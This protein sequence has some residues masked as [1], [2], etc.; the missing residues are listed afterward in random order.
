MSIVP[1]AAQVGV[2]VGSGDY[3][4]S[5][6][7][8][9]VDLIAA[10]D[11][12]KTGF[13]LPTGQPLDN[14]WFPFSTQ[15][16]VQNG[17]TYAVMI[18]AQHHFYDDASASVDCGTGSGSTSGSPPIITPQDVTLFKSCLP[19][20]PHTN[21]GILGQRWECQVDVTAAVTPF[22]GDIILHDVFS[23][24]PLVNGQILLG[25]SVS[26][27]GSCFQGDCLISGANFD[28]SGS[29]SFTFDVFVEASG[30]ADVYP[31]ENCVTGEIDDGS[32]TLQPLT[33][34]CTTDQWVPRSQVVKTCDPMPENATAPYTMNCSIEVT[35]SG[36]VGGTYVSV[37]DAF[38]AQPPSVATVQ[39]TFM[40]VTSTENWDCID[41]QLN[42][43]GSIGICELPAE[44]LMA[45]GGTSTLDISFQF[46]VDQAPTQVAN[47]RFTDI[48]S[49]SYL[50][51][52][53]GQRSALRS[54]IQSGTNQNSGW[55]QMP[56]GCVYVDVP[57]PQ[58]ETKVETK[59]TK[60]C[61]QPTL[62]NHNGTWGYLWQCE[63]EVEVTPSPFAGTVSFTDDGSQ[64]SMVTSE[65]VSVSDPLC[66]GLGTDTLDCT[67]Q[68]ATFS[69]PHI[70]HY[71]LF[72]PY[73]QTDE[74]IEWKNCIRGA[75]ETAAGT[76]P[77]VP[78][79]TGRFIKPT[80][81]PV[82]D[83]PKDI[84]L[85]KVCE[86]DGRETEYDGQAG[87]AWDC[88][89]IVTAAP[90]PF[91]GTFTFTENASSITGSTGQI[92]AIDQPQPADWTCLPNVPTAATDCT[93]AGANF[94][95]SGT[96]TIGFTLF[97]PNSGETVE[98]KNCVSGFYTPDEKGDTG[99]EP[100]EVK[101]NCEGITWKPTVV[102]TPPSFDIKKSCRG[103]FDQRE[104][105]QSY[106]CTIFITQTGGDPITQPLTLNELFSSTTTGQSATQFMIGLQGTT[107]WDCDMS[108]ASCSILPADFNGN[109]GHQI[110]A[111]FL[112]PNGT[113]VEQDFQNCASLTMGDAE[114]AN[115]P[116]VDLDEPIVDPVGDPAF[117][118]EKQ[119]KPLGERQVMGPSAWFQ[120]WSCTITVT[121]NGVP[122]ADP[123][124]IDEDMLYGSNDGSQSVTSITS[125]DP[126]HC[127]PAP[128]GPNGN[129]PVCGIQGNQ[130]PHNTSTLDVTLN[131]FG[132][133][134]DQ[135]GA[136]NCVSV[137]MGEISNAAAGD[138]LA[139]DCFE[140]IA[141]PEPKEPQIDLVKTC[142][143][144]TQTGTGQWSV[145]C[146]LTITGQNLP[147]GEQFRVTDE[148]MSSNTQ[149]ATFGVMNAGTN[150]CGGGPIAGG[151]MAGCDLTT[152]MINANGGTLSI[153]YTGT[154]VGPAGR[155]LDGPRAQNCAFVDVPGLGLHGP[156]GGNGKSCVP[157]E[158]KETISS[159][160]SDIA[161]DPEVPGGGSPDVGGV[162]V[163]NPPLDATGVATPFVPAPAEPF[164]TKTCEPLVFA[165][166]AQTATANCEITVGFPANDP[167][168]IN[169]ITD[170]MARVGAFGDDIVVGN[171]PPLTGQQQMGCQS[172]PPA[173]T[174]C[175]G[176]SLSSM[177]AGGTFTLNWTAEI[178]R[179]QDEREVYRNCAALYFGLL[180][181]ASTFLSA[182]HVFDITVEG[183]KAQDADATPAPTPTP[184]PIIEH[185]LKTRKLQNTDCVA[186]RN[187]Q[188]YTCGFRITVTNEGTAPYNGPLVVTDTF[189]SPWA[190]AITQTSQGGWFCAQPVG[191]AVSC[192]H[193]GLN[194]PAG[195]FAYI[196]LDMEVQ[197][198]VNGGQW[199]NCAAVGIP[200]DRKQRVAAIQQVM[201]A[202]GLAAGPVDGLPGAKTYAALAELQKSLGLPIS[203]EF[204]DALFAALGLPLAKPGEKSC[205]VADLPNMPKPPLQCERATTV[206]KGESCQC[207]YDNM[208]RRNATACQCTGGYAFVAG[209]GCVK[210]IVTP[211]P[212]PT[213]PPLL[214]TRTC[215]KR[216]TRLRGDECVCLDQKNAVK[217]SDTTCGCRNGGPMIGGKCLPITITPK[218][219]NPDATD[220]PVGTSEPDKCK[221]RLN[222]ICIK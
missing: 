127:S 44:D 164:I 90:A 167:R 205:V 170:I 68:G 24:T 51:K 35:G 69:S 41:H 191:G 74:K 115:A 45:A 13:S 207:R 134:A 175:T 82:F 208:I 210:Q 92:I 149:T 197:G 88:K 60:D 86:E 97:A 192:E 65:F 48:H 146:T 50:D 181:T 8:N 54:P 168:Q 3:P 49:G 106:A 1:V 176:P 214:E 61:D 220:D 17:Q 221:I 182:C 150:A 19:P 107:G 110:G 70:V 162:D 39:P 52:L 81:V 18:E 62:T 94:D 173:A 174:S 91:A 189:G 15:S 63:A 124:W 119:C 156:A 23:N 132:G 130:F 98:W 72:T 202:R 118:V 141:P 194:L 163:T 193:S 171:M 122:F 139:E 140:I 121:S 133:A 100:R 101:G 83:P 78:M 190:Q 67:Y 7:Q 113:L 155:P 75:A 179:P 203:R 169:R 114:V 34:H 157:V 2:Y 79:C 29:E 116:C 96:E 209:E 6:A 76:F 12:A 212:E 200:D 151:T 73:I 152:D 112:I 159:G 206:Q 183:G 47:C 38:A 158:F 185:T 143:P 11:L 136:E 147:N 32:G 30:E 204:D 27:N 138:V 184:A 9:V 213:P 153:P 216:S 93:I 186:D 33:P 64:I 142:E 120:L 165:G 172:N 177:S 198:L 16:A 80:D 211:K 103:P 20:V 105:G 77:S 25:E 217:T 109:T 117:E 123:L 42:T 10:H 108:T 145:A 104:D 95:A 196:D 56:D 135:F 89:I 128:Y 166:G 180:P 131:I 87:L 21:N 40:N 144:A 195:S 125:N 66:T 126:W 55:P 46:D 43:P 111:F 26:G 154:Y 22:A 36:L 14:Q 222:G 199:E 37:M 188:R 59:I 57:G 129:Q 178:E 148:L 161:I 201:N 215:D 137:G 53:S 219:G 4:V 5:D 99:G 58:L 85:E 71:D 102:S 31:L 218:P 187:T 28:A 160:V 84:K